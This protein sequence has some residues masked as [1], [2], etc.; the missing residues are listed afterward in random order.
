MVT[1]DPVGAQMFAAPPAPPSP[2]VAPASAQDWHGAE[3]PP[4]MPQFR[5]SAKVKMETEESTATQAKRQK[6]T[7]A[8][9]EVGEHDSLQCGICKTTLRLSRLSAHFSGG[10]QGP[11]R[12]ALCGDQEMPTSCGV[13]QISDSCAK[14]V[15]KLCKNVYSANYIYKH[16]C[17]AKTKANKASSEREKAK[18]DEIVSGLRRQLAEAEREKAKLAVALERETATAKETAS[19]LRKQLA[20]ALEREQAKAAENANSLQLADVLEK[21][22]ARAE[23]T[24]SALRKQLAEA[25]EREQAKAEENANS[26]QLADVLE[27]EKAKAEETAS[28][29]R[30]Q[31]AEASQALEA[32]QETAAGLATPEILKQNLVTLFERVHPDPFFSQTDYLFRG[33]EK[34]GNTSED[35][36]IDLVM[37]FNAAL[38]RKQSEVLELSKIVLPE[39]GEPVS[40]D[41]LIR[42]LLKIFSN[43]RDPSMPLILAH[44][45]SH[46]KGFGVSNSAD[47]KKT[48]CCWQHEH[49]DGARKSLR[50]QELLE[51]HCLE[52][53]RVFAP[54]R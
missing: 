43:Q 6:L 22:K 33:P 13:L 19:A 46:L 2:P 28:A 16:A 3:L 27:K 15:C 37:Q 51:N 39:F 52:G 5:G 12:L 21:E 23:E 8:I 9:G 11:S 44:R 41:K 14:L 1:P 4:R 38:K 45:L 32:A 36:H 30:K 10:C 49:A 25:L 26:L 40:F 29:L 47:E 53:M 18:S 24:A 31:L 48:H 50:H 54:G 35:E 17:K 34:E 20:E 7:E 42:H